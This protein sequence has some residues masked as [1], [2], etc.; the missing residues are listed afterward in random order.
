MDFNTAVERIGFPLAVILFEDRI[1]ENAWQNATVDQCL[2]VRYA[3]SKGI[4]EYIGGKKMHQSM[5][6]NANKRLQTIVAEADFKT[7]RALCDKDSDFLSGIAY[8]RLFPLT[9]T[10]EEACEIGEVIGLWTSSSS[11][12]LQDPKR[13]RV[14][15][16]CFSKATRREHF[17]KLFNEINYPRPMLVGYLPEEDE[18]KAAEKLLEDKPS[19]KELLLGYRFPPSHPHYARALEKD[20]EMIPWLDRFHSLYAEVIEFPD[21][22]N[23]VATAFKKRLESATLKGNHDPYPYCKMCELTTKYGD[24][25]TANVCYNFIIANAEKP[26]QERFRQQGY[27]WI[28][29]HADPE[30]EE[31]KKFKALIPTKRQKKQSAEV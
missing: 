9:S 1:P 4:T 20:L 29:D 15:Q 25:E 17:A 23:K 12:D 24:E 30:S 8:E 6:E 31:Y 16:L 14:T 2:R 5:W 19:D 7:A 11:N 22:R 10:F 3:F 27:R 21:H 18:L 13:A 26:E 28:V